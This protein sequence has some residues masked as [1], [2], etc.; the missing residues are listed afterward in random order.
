[1]CAPVIEKS[2]RKLPGVRAVGTNYLMNTVYVDFDPVRTTAEA[3]Q[4]RIE[5]LGYRVVRPRGM[6]GAARR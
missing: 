5:D 3:I 4:R 2:V 1:M 6:T